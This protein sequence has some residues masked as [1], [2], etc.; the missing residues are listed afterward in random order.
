MLSFFSRK[1]GALI[2]LNSIV[3]RT[4]ANVLIWKYMYVSMSTNIP[5]QISMTIFYILF[6]PVAHKVHIY[7]EYHS[8]CPL[9]GI[10]TPPPLAPGECPPPLWFGGRGTLGG[11]WGGGRVP[12]STRGHILWYS[13]YICTLWSTG[14]NRISKY[15]HWDLIWDISTH[16]YVHIFPDQYKFARVPATIEFNNISAP[17]QRMPIFIKSYVPNSS[18]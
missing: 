16:T 6:D 14:S 15:S 11:E 18:T 13:V 12:I 5:Y 1:K 10:G 9:V 8:I 7:T 3:A 17:L 2:L 4:L